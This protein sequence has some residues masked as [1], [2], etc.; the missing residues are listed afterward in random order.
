[1]VSDHHNG[2]GTKGEAE[3]AAS[4]GVET[5][6]R[7]S[8]AK[9]IVSGSVKVAFSF[10]FLWFVLDKIGFNNVID[11]IAKIPTSYLLGAWVAM[12]LSLL[13]SAFRMR[14][15]FNT[16]GYKFTVMFSIALYYIGALLNLALPGG[17]G[18]D[19]YKAWLFKKYF[20][21]RVRTS[22]RLLLSERASGVLLLALFTLVAL[23]LG[24][25][26]AHIPYLGSY[27]VMLLVIG[28]VMLFP[29]YFIAISVLLKETARIAIGAAGYS[30]LIQGLVLVCGALLLI[31]LGADYAYIPDYIAL[32]LLS[33]ILAV[34]PISVGGAGV[35]ELTFLYGS[36][37]LGLPPE[38][39]IAAALL[40]FGV[41]AASCVVAL[42]FLY[43][44]SRRINHQAR[45][46]N[47]CKEN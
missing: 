4:G 41:Y 18:G 47:I 19:G 23:L 40:F 32:F 43:G 44:M 30:F 11:H 38:F 35:R 33:N 36:P 29:S 2:S 26:K 9:R 12:V 6:P 15:Y 13:V 24:E 27:S 3:I 37:L 21:L 46:L 39:G 10:L 20:G 42:P 8:V 31:G 16:V 45:L 22:V 17:I 34:L 1:M 5:I 25:G 7:K 28:I 14:Y